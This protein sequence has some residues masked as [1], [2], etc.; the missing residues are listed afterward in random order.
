MDVELTNK[1]RIGHVWNSKDNYHCP[2]QDLDCCKPHRRIEYITPS[3]N[4]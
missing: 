3:E 2:E 1:T 4:F